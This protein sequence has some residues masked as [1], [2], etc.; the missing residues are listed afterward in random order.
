MIGCIQHIYVVDHSKVI[1]DVTKFSTSFE[2]HFRA[3]LLNQPESGENGIFIHQ[4]QLLM[5]SPVHI[6]KSHALG[7]NKYIILPHTIFSL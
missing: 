7:V 3:Y 6:R 5:R 4:T 2:P 1:F